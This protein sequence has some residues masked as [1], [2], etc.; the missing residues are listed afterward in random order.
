MN[1]HNLDDLAGSLI[2]LIVAIVFVLIIIV[3][4]CNL[5]LVVTI[6]S[7]HSL[8]MLVGSVGVNQFVSVEVITHQGP[9]LTSY[10]AKK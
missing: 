6:S 3:S 4:G 5:G 7:H 1:I 9:S 10:C 2:D 8:E